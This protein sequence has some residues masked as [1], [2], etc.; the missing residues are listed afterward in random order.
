MK[1]VLF[2][3]FISFL[4]LFV[5]CS[6]E[7]KKTETNKTSKVTT[8]DFFKAVKDG[9]I[10]KVKEMISNDK[11]L[12]NAIDSSSG[13]NETALGIVTF[14]GKKELTELL[15]KNGANV[16]FQD[17]FGVA[18]LHGAAR[19]NQLEV[20]KILLENKADVNLPT[21]TGKETPLHYAARYNNADVVKLLL[22][23]G[24][25]KNALDAS[26]VSPLEAAKKENADNVIPLLK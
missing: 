10:D 15:I 26:G 20:I 2:L 17:A 22:D 9:K 4:I 7:D 6:K 8:A 3:F 23:K 12:V 24:A 13:I 11:T 25:N 1:K 16:N 19:T 18:P 5:S 14:S 21:T